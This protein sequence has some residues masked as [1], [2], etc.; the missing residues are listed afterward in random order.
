MAGRKCMQIWYILLSKHSLVYSF[1]LLTLELWAKIHCLGCPEITLINLLYLHL[2]CKDAGR[3]R[4]PRKEARRGWQVLTEV[5][6]KKQA[7]KAIYQDN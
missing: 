7:L 5:R 2:L 4:T 1:C 3:Q 6:L